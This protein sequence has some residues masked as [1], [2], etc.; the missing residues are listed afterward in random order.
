MFQDE[1]IEE[2][3]YQVCFFFKISTKFLFPLG[4]IDYKINWDNTYQK[5]KKKKEHLSFE[6][7]SRTRDLSWPLKTIQHVFT[8][9]DFQLFP[10]SFHF[11]N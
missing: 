7:V 4:A 9:N 10:K 2:I 6:N 11:L 8:E 5:K 3:S 1:N